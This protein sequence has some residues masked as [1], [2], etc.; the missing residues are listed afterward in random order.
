[1]GR[2]LPL[3]SVCFRAIQFFNLAQVLHLQVL[4]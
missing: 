1:M 4:H 2:F 3:A